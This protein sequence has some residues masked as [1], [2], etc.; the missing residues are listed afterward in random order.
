MKGGGGGGCPDIRRGERGE[1][2]FPPLFSI[3]HGVGL[4]T[5]TSQPP[6]SMS[7]AWAASKTSHD[8]CAGREMLEKWCKIKPKSRIRG[9]GRGRRVGIGVGCRHNRR[10]ITADLHRGAVLGTGHPHGHG[11]VVGL[12]RRG[13]AQREVGLRDREVLGPEDRKWAS[14]HR[15]ASA[16]QHPLSMGTTCT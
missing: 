9:R 7:H 12:H 14:Q 11:V 16:S 8:A 6:T 5:S 15:I 2:L 4:Q 13:E 10:R 3:G 1:S